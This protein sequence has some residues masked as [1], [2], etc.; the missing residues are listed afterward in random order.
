MKELLV[1]ACNQRTH[2]AIH[3]AIAARTELLQ[4]STN[5][6]QNITHKVIFYYLKI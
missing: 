3:S 4:V 1:Y 6:F 2:G 5:Y